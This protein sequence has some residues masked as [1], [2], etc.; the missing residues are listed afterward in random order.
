MNKDKT[1]TLDKLIE[2]AKPSINKELYKTLIN[3]VV[4]TKTDRSVKQIETIVKMRIENE[5]DKIIWVIIKKV[6]SE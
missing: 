4:N 2:T 3:E 5:V 1:I 6:L